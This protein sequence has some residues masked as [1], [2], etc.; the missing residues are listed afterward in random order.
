MIDF[1]LFE[2]EGRIEVSVVDSVSDMDLEIKLDNYWAWI[3]KADFNVVYVTESNGVKTHTY[4]QS[5]EQYF[6]ENERE[7]IKTHMIEYLRA[8]KKIKL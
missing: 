4:K 3:N 8:I 1:E 6:R 2:K 7:V 5:R